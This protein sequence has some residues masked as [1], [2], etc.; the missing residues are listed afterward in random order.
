MVLHGWAV[1]MRGDS[2]AGIAEIRGSLEAQLAAGALI[3]RPQFCAILADACLHAGDIN[4]ALEAIAEGLECSARTAD[5][6][7]DSELHRLR[8]EALVLGDASDAEVDACFERAIAD[9]RAREAKSLEL[10]A[11]TNAA[12]VWQARGDGARGRRVL[13]PVHDWFTEGFAT[14]DLLAARA[15]L[16]SLP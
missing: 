15:L 11:A 3:A 6:Y 10:R 14:R 8:G 1:A 5:R 12:R 7:W 13:Q 9:T 2:A 4:G 16:A